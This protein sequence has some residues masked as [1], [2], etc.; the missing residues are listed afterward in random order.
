MIDD[1]FSN[2]TPVIVQDQHHR[3]ELKR[4]LFH[5]IKA[6]SFYPSKTTM[7]ITYIAELQSVGT[8]ANATEQAVCD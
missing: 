3:L 7:E 4:Q 6:S 2:R 1:G 8:P 5:Q